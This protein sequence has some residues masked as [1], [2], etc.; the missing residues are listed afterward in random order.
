MLILA[1]EAQKMV[2]EIRRLRVRE[3]TTVALRNEK[4]KPRIVAMFHKIC[5]SFKINSMPVSF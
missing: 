5:E 2:K 3:E 1:L 4:R